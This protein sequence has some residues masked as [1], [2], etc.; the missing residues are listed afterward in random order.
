[1]SEFSLITHWH[2]DA[3]IDRV[4]GAIRAVEQW[5]QWWRYVHEVDELTPGDAGGIGALRRYT[6]SSRL[7]YRLSFEM[8]VTRVEKRSSL[9]GVAEG[10]LR[11]SGRWHLTPEGD[12][13][14]VRY[15]WTVITTKPWMNVL[16]PLLQPAFRWNHNEGHGRR[17]PRK[18]AASRRQPSLSSRLARCRVTGFRQS[19][20]EIS[21]PALG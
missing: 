14:H 11:G 7:P 20:C 10:D 21:P 8:R 1:M 12:T 5:P 3:P 4:W 9:E 2:L 15:D 16:G 19:A 17:R 13:T 6:W 18:C